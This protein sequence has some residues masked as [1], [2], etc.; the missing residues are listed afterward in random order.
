MIT[1]RALGVAKGLM[2]PILK[3]DVDGGST[4]KDVVKMLPE[5][6]QEMAERKELSLMVNGADVS[7]LDGAATE[8]K[9]GD[10]LVLLPFA[11][12]GSQG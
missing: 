1:V 2:G 4:V 9:D 3:L 5:G 8:L 12:G 11:H 10:E 7:T 6:L